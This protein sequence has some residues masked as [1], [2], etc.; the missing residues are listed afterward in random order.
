MSF[1]INAG[2][3]ITGSTLPAGDVT[4]Y[5]HTT[6]SPAPAGPR[7]SRWS[8]TGLPAG[9]SLNSS[10]GAMSPERAARYRH[11]DRDGH[12]HGQ[13]RCDGHEGPVARRSMPRRR[14]T[15]SL[16][17]GSDG[18]AYSAT[19]AG[20]GGATAYSWS[21]TGLPAGLSTLSSSTGVISGTPTA[22]GYVHRRRSRSPTRSVDREP[23]NF[24]LTIQPKISSVTLTNKASGGTAGKMEAGD[25]ITIVYSGADE[26]RQL[27]QR[28]GRGTAR[29][30]R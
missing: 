16:P 19:V 14:S 23:T 24:S 6:R 28:R 29:T 30:R 2:P 9:L 25:T 3:S 20:A 4:S 7:P 27:L 17:N 18:V 15:T 5:V 12:A 26:R 13:R 11:H 8:A 22:S 1:T 21:A 10:H